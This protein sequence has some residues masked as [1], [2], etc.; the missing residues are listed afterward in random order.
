M[1]KGFQRRIIKTDDGSHSLELVGQG[2]HYHSTFGAVQE[3]R[4][5][6]IQRGLL[7]LPHKETP[8]HILEVGFGTGLN[9][10]LT[11]IESQNQGIQVHYFTL[12]PFPLERE[13]YE[14][15]N[16]P[17]I[18]EQGKYAACF[19]AFHQCEWDKPVEI[20]KGFSFHK[21]RY[22]LKEAKLSSGFFD[23]VYFDAFGPDTQPELW[24]Q[25]L[26]EKVFN[27]MHSAGVLVTYCAKGMVKRALRACGFTI[28]RLPGPPGK[29]EMTRAVKP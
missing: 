13:E 27:A 6:F 25:A 15:L 24:E 18:L 8:I 26:F 9:A 4:H 16:Y 7:S 5:V 20:A 10:L 12:E 23:L 28:E 29:R 2:E 22:G 1:G 14:V 17:Q 11:F 21:T 3:S 19:E